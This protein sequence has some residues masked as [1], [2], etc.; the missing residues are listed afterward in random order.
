VAGG[1]YHP[2]GGSN[3]LAPVVT[4]TATNTA[5]AGSV[6]NVSFFAQRGSAVTEL[7]RV[8]AAP[9]TLNW[10]NPAPGRY[11]LTAVGQSDAGGRG[12]SAPVRFDV[13]VP[14]PSVQVTNSFTGGPYRWT[15]SVRNG[16]N[17]T[18]FYWTN[19]ASAGGSA[20]GEIFGLLAGS[21]FDDQKWIGDAH[22]NGWLHPA[23]QNL[24]VRGRLRLE[25]INFSDTFIIGFHNTGRPGDILGLAHGLTGDPN[26]SG[27][28][29]IVGSFSASS[30]FVIPASNSVPFELNWNCTNN[31]ITGLVGAT[32]VNHTDAPSMALGR[33]FDGMAL[34]T[35]W[36]SLNPGRQCKVWLDDLSYTM[37][38]QPR[39]TIERTGSQVT[40][41]WQGAGYLLQSSPSLAPVVWTNR[42]RR[43]PPRTTPRGEPLRDGGAALFPLDLVSHGRHSLHA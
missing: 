27:F 28:P 8:A 30:I 1:L 36:G 2:R 22:L 7:D 31:T 14:L 24:T 29:A 12:T 33:A 13:I 37:V 39:L 20:G 5:N 23:F 9:F 6:T 34:L 35:T 3:T 16:S 25:D 15:D 42:P 26:P 18:A 21:T 11:F 38:A 4:L 43:R 17:G 32:T 41:R 10:T 40:L 19:T